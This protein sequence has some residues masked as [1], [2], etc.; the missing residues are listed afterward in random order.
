M[1]ESDLTLEKVLQTGQSMEQAQHY[2]STIE[3]KSTLSTS[4]TSNQ[5]ELN[6]LRYYRHSPQRKHFKKIIRTKIKTLITET[7]ISM[8]GQKQH[9]SNNQIECSRCCAKGQRGNECR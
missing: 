3:Q 5:E 2:S 8:Q 9:T 1:T 4:E 7:H 6:A